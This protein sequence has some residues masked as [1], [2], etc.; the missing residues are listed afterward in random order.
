M[1]FA[2]LLALGSGISSI[3]AAPPSNDNFANRITLMEGVT[4]VADTTDATIEPG[5]PGSDSR[6]TVWYTWTATNDSIVSIDNIGS[7]IEDDFVAVHIG[8]SLDKLV[9]VDYQGYFL[10][11][12]GGEGSGC[13][14]LLKLERNCKFKRVQL[15]VVRENC[16]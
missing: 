13:L 1:L 3:I 10:T 11:G 9:Y 5:E 12:G 6:R 15:A 14:S 16:R 7:D 2:V 4:A 8:V